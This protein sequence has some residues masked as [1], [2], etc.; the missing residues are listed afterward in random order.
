MLKQP[1]PKQSTLEMVTLE[2]LV[3]ADHLLRQIDRYIDFDFIR[4]ATEHLYC[5]NNGRPA[6]D[7][8]LLFKMLFIGYLFGVRSERQLVREVQVNVAYRWFL[9]MGLTDKVPDASTFSQNRRRRYEGSGIEQLIFDRIVEQAMG[10]GLVGGKAL[11]TDSTHLKANANKRRHTTHE[12][13]ITPMAYIE[14]LNEAVDADR[15]AHGKK[16]LPAASRPAKRKPT[17]IS[18]TDPDA[19]YMVR[20]Q[21]PEGFFYLDHR[22][23]DGQHNIITDSHLTPGNINDARPY[24]DRLDRQCTR[25]KLKPLVVAL[26]AGYNT[27]GVCHGLVERGID[28]VV[29]YKRPH[30]PKGQFS[31]RQFEYD[32]EQDVYRCPGGQALP[33]KTTNRNG[34][35]EYKSNPKVCKECPLLDQ[36][37]RSRQHQKVVVRHVW[38]DDREQINHNRM[39]A[40]GKQHYRR[41]CETVE[42]SFADA[43]QLHG[44]RY[45]RFRGLERVRAQCLLAAACQNMKKIARVRAVLW[46][47]LGYLRPFRSL[48]KRPGP[49]NRPTHRCT[50]QYNPY[51]RKPL[52]H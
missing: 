41:R 31:K 28:G 32:P 17:K 47:F 13:E 21:K 36:C 29:G 27:T 14:E 48:L 16:P 15:Q 25:F 37:T 9:G 7:P 23:V 12:V 52:I 6:I 50:A 18:E 5:D 33:Y 24:L 22:T 20:D 38:E 10:H 3:P 45:A 26:D 49:L 44:H 43:K 4:E 42:R 11:Y 19:G 39:T 46:V 40:W 34:Y 51:L 8:V 35:R 2:E 1:T 30:R